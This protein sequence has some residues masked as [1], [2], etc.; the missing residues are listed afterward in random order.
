ME[1]TRKEYRSWQ[2]WVAWQRLSR[3]RNKNNEQVF[4][5]QMRDYL[6]QEH[7]LV[8]SDNSQRL[9][10]TDVGQRIVVCRVGDY[11]SRRAE[12]ES[13]AK[14]PSAK[15][16]PQQPLLALRIPIRDLPKREVWCRNPKT[17][18][19]RMEESGM[20]RAAMARRA[21]EIR[22]AVRMAVVR[23]RRN[24]MP[25]D[26]CTDITN[27]LQGLPSSA[28]LM[29]SLA[30]WSWLSKW[31]IRKIRNSKKPKNTNKAVDRDC[32]P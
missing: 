13:L 17:G 11:C 6:K 15:T 16:I 28:P 20:A 24:G 12:A 10:W 30:V 9:A 4:P 7:G 29:C 21:Q 31:K 3:G 8:G 14:T 23:E 22:G 25:H 32:A 19:W 5:R 18:P 26:P 27:L 1:A 2:W